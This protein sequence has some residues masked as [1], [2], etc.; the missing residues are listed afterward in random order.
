MYF[1]FVLIVTVKCAARIRNFTE[2]FD[3]P[4]LQFSANSPPSAIIHFKMLRVQ[5]VVLLS[6][7][8]CI[9]KVV[10]IQI[11]FAFA[12]TVVFETVV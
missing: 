9:C 7:A 4:V 10:L 12:V 5:S 3:N 1:D 8:F 6:L 11:F 2:E